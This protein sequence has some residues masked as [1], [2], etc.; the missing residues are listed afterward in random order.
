[1]PS[2]SFNLGDWMQNLPSPPNINVVQNYLIV[3]SLQNRA[4][5]TSPNH[6][7]FILYP[8]PPRPPP[9]VLKLIRLKV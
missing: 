3:S 7:I 9:Q 1:M 5:F 6:G 8:P 4:H 2:G